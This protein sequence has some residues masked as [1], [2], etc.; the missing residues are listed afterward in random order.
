M[1]LVKRQK[2]SENDNTEEY[3]VY[4]TIDGDEPTLVGSDE[5]ITSRSNHYMTGW[6]T[7]NFHMRRRR[8]DL[9]PMTPF[10]ETLYSGSTEGSFDYSHTNTS[11][12]TVRYYSSGNWVGRPEWIVSSEEIHSYVDLADS[13]VYVQQAAARIYSSGYDAL[14]AVA[15]LAE[16][17]HMFI[18]IAKRLIKMDFP[19]SIRDV[20]CDWLESRYGWR[21]LIYDIKDLNQAIQKFDETRTRYSEKA[22]GQHS[23]SFTTNLQNEWAYTFF[24]TVVEDK[25]TISNSGSIVADIT[26]PKIQINPLVTGWEL[27]PFSFVLDWFVSVGQSL[28]AM[29]F[30]LLQHNYTAAAGVQVVVERTLTLTEGAAKDSLISADISQ[31]A[32]FWARVQKRHPTTVPL[33]PRLML[34]LNAFKITDLLALIVQR[35]R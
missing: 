13:N 1:S 30:L 28:S 29:S 22:H 19:K 4:R 8:G 23:T 12:Q 6:D 20:S 3:E 31:T 21:T 24:D 11:S 15:E 18:N 10:E 17:R 2:Q 9:I 34:K 27:I 32:S 14:T 25:V 35:F 26:I 33:I 7:P 5:A 16:V